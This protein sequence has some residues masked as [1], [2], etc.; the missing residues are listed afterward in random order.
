[1]TSI[2]LK[3]WARRGPL[4]LF[5]TL[6]ILLAMK[7]RATSVEYDRSRGDHALTY[8]IDGVEYAMVA[9]DE[10]IAETIER[11]VRE[12]VSPPSFWERVLGHVPIAVQGEF[13]IAVGPRLATVE[14]RVDPLRSKVT[15]NLS[16]D[17]SMAKAAK[18]ALD[19][20]RDE[21]PPWAEGTE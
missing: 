13:P 21:S 15:L 14:A 8:Q 7:D 1:M 20:L 9:P 11:T 2:D 4:E 19:K 5:W 12:L 6:V 18:V 3:L 10:E 16:P 17:S